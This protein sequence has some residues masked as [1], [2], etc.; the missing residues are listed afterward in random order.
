MGLC[1]F[2]VAQ[3]E[4]LQRTGRELPQ[5]LQVELHVANQQKELCAFCQQHGIVLMSSSPL[6]RGQ[7]L[8]TSE[9]QQ[10]A[11]QRRR[12]SA[13]LA[14][15]W[16]LQRGFVMIPKSKTPARVESNAAFG[17]VLSEEDMKFF[18]TLDTKLVI[19]HGQSAMELPWEELLAE[20]SEVSDGDVG[21]DAP[22][23]RRRRKKRGKGQGKGQPSGKGGKGQG[24]AY[25]SAQRAQDVLF[26]LS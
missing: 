16:G 5:V 4:A 21:D 24:A 8:R 1:N 9:L 2:S 18:S 3:L 26:R 15:R 22:K 7:L 13:E 25:L 14:I 19:G 12:S 17:F 6:A 23:R 11:F 10:L 20:V